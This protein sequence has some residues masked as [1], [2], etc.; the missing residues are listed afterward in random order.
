MTRKIWWGDFTTEEFQ[1]LDPDRTIAVLPIAAIEQHGPHLPVSTDSS[2]MGG[3]LDTVIK[4]A[5]DDLDIRILPIQSVGK[6]NEHQH[7]AGTLTIPATTLI[8]HWVELGH[9]IARAGIR[10]VVLVNSHGGNEE[11]M[12][13]VARE[14]R[15]R[16]RMLAV[17][18]SWMR[19]GLPSGLYSETETSYGIHGGDVETSLMLHFRPDLVAMDKA[20]NFVSA[21]TRAEKEFDLLRHT[22]P[23]AFAWIASDLNSNGAVGEAALATAQKGEATARH[24]AEGFLR[25]MV[26]VRAAKLDDWL[27]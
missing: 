1:G 21:V 9:S 22:G 17:K 26:D 3:M 19:F 5:P 24:Q 7:A 2:I 15:V 6:S 18:T 20:E 27:A 10:K 11:V 12:G 25:L 14:L 23:H 16:A 8:D 13:I 4:A